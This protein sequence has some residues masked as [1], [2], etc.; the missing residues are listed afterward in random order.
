MI[1]GSREDPHTAFPISSV[2]QVRIHW[3]THGLGE[4]DDRNWSVVRTDSGSLLGSL[5]RGI[6]LSSN[7]SSSG[8]KFRALPVS[9][10]AIEPDGEGDMRFS[11]AIYRFA[12]DGQKAEVIADFTNNTWGLGFSNLSDYRPPVAMDVRESLFVDR[13]QVGK[14][15]LH[16]PEER[17]SLWAA[18]FVDS[19]GGAWH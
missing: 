11:Q 9:S 4:G 6:G 19:W 13:V 8:V 5:A 7:V 1:A 10:S 17:G 14:V 3:E 2:E 16:E 18:R 12:P 15:I